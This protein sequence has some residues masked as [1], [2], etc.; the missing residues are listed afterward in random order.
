MA[1]EQSIWSTAKNF[2]SLSP[3]KPIPSP[4]TAERKELSLPIIVETRRSSIPK[5][6]NAD[7]VYLYEFGSLNMP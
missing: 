1:T 4:V 3:K 6:A 5:D 2:F 7:E